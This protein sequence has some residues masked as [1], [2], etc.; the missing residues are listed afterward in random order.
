MIITKT[1]FR[2]SLF[3]GSTDYPSFYKEH[4]SLL[5]GFTFN[6][7]NY[8]SIR[9]TPSILDYHT[10]LHYSKVETVS[11]N[12]AIFHNGIRGTLQYLNIQD[13]IEL[14]N[15]SDLPAQ[16]GVGSSSSFIVGLI[17]ALNRL[18]NEEQL[19]RKELAQT[20]R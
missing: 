14:S 20:L 13:G 16:T 8:L 19:P 15:L 12:D 1:P 6:K 18:Y 11:N 17:K 9:Q 4:G 10:R 3:G 2:I 5:I 7:Y